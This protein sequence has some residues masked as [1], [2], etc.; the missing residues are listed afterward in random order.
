MWLKDVRLTIKLPTISI[1]YHT[2]LAFQCFLYS[3]EQCRQT[4]S[5]L[6]SFSSCYDVKFLHSSIATNR[7]MIW[8]YCAGFCLRRQ[9]TAN[10]EVVRAVA[11][12][13]SVVIYF[14][15]GLVVSFISIFN[16]N[17]KFRVRKYFSS[18]VFNATY[19]SDGLSG[20]ATYNYWHWRDLSKYL[21]CLWDMPAHLAKMKKTHFSVC[22]LLV[23]SSIYAVCGMEH[24]FNYD[25]SPHAI[26]KRSTL[27]DHP[28]H[29][30]PTADDNITTVVCIL[31]AILCLNF[32]SFQENIYD[33][34]NS[35]G[36]WTRLTNYSNTYQV[37]IFGHSGRIVPQI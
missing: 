13:F 26:Q 8:R 29:A 2:M 17:N 20:F 23:M 35:P 7:K 25:G 30:I 5:W 32:S 33:L 12:A 27:Q 36:G 6:V 4:F 37:E 24:Y 3:S 34:I 14:G 15:S 21:S 19:L 11:G 22:L 10:C 16:F 1:C 28:E 9:S 18:G 31:L